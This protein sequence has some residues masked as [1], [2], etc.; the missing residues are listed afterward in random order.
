M[1][2]NATVGVIRQ[3]LMPLWI[4]LAGI[5]LGCMFV[6]SSLPKIRHPYEFLCSVYDYEFV[7]PQVGMLT[8]M[9][10]PWLELL[11]G[12]CLIGGIWLAGALLASTGLGLL[13]SIALGSALYRGLKISCGCFSTSRAEVI[14]YS[15]LVR[16]GLILVLSITAH[17][18][19]ILQL[20][21]QHGGAESS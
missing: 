12:L 5:A 17:L 2:W 7:G 19:L 1:K 16:A 20:H 8:A 13:F 11:V 6:Y 21:E 10:L 18:C 9:I 15:T 14:D 4:R 3:R